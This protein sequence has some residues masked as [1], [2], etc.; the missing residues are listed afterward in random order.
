V[1]RRAAT[2]LVAALVVLPVAAG[3]HEV[4]HDV[5][6][7]RAVGVRAYFADGEALAYTQFEV[8]SPSDPKIPH[9]KGRT[10]RSGWV[11]FVPDAPGKWHVKVIDNTGHGLAV[12]VE[13]GA[14][15]PAP[16]PGGGGA[17]ASSLA[18]ILRPVVGI[19]VIVGVFAAIAANHRRKGRSS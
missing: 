13:A 15:G 17:G 4:L 3:A 14:A 18:F 12:E 8:Y 10:D 2:A 16:A 7:G 5:E 6:R 9:Q 1:S 19:V 11:A